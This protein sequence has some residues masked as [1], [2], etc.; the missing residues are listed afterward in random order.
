ML[1][2]YSRNRKNN[3]EAYKSNALSKM[4]QIWEESE[5]EIAR[6]RSELDEK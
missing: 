3:L 4:S 6:L 2:K 1:M 5:L